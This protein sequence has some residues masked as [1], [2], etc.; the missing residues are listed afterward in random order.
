MSDQGAATSVA[1]SDASRELLRNTSE[2]SNTTNGSSLAPINSQTQLLRLETIQDSES[3][4]VLMAMKL[5]GVLG[6]AGAIVL[7]VIKETRG[8]D[9]IVLNR[10]FVIGQVVC[11]ATMFLALTIV[12]AFW[13]WRIV[14]SYRRG[15]VWSTRR[16]KAVQAVF[17]RAVVIFIIVGGHLFLNV[18]L[19]ADP[20]S[21]CTSHVIQPVVNAFVWVSWNTLLCLLAIDSHCTNLLES[22]ERSDGMVRDKPLSYHWPKLFVWIPYTISVLWISAM[23][24]EDGHTI[25]TRVVKGGACS[26]GAEL[27]CEISPFLFAGTIVTFVAIAAY[28]AMFAYYLMRAWRQLSGQLY[29]RYRMVNMAVRLQFRFNGGMVLALI[30]GIALTWY[31]GSDACVNYAVTWYGNPPVTF[32]I[33]CFQLVSFN[34]TF[35]RRHDALTTQ[36]VLPTAILQQFAWTEADVPRKIAARV[37]Y[38]DAACAA[39]PTFIAKPLFCLETAIKLFFW[40]VLAYSYT[41]TSGVSFETMPAPIKAL[42]GEMDAAMRLFNLS[43]RHLFY[44][45]QLGTKVLVA[46][47]S[48]TIVVTVRGSAEMANY[49]QDAKFLQTAHPPRRKF[50]GRTPRVH[51]GFLA[52]WRANGIRTRVLAHISALLDSADDRSA[53]RV[54]CTGHSLGGAVAQLASF[55]I[56]RELGVSPRNI[57]VYTYGCPRIGNHTLSAEF[58]EVVPDTWHVINDQDVVTRTMKMFGLYKRAG[59]R[60]II[61]RHGDLI[62]RPNHFELSMLQNVRGGST[63]HHMTVAYQNALVAIVSSQLQASSRHDDGLHGLLGLLK[64]MP[65]V[66]AALEAHASQ[67]GTSL[68]DLVRNVAHSGIDPARSTTFSASQRF[69]PSRHASLLRAAGSADAIVAV[70]AVD[71]AEPGSPASDTSVNVMPVAMLEPEEDVGDAPSMLCQDVSPAP[72]T[73]GAVG[74]AAPEAGNVSDA[75]AAA[76]RLQRWRSATNKARAAVRIS[77]SVQSAQGAQPDA[78]KPATLPAEADSV[79]GEEIAAKYCY[80]IPER[81]G[82]AGEGRG[83]YEGPAAGEHGAHKKK[84]CRWHCP[85]TCRPEELPEGAKLRGCLLEMGEAPDMKSCKG[86]WAGGGSVRMAAAAA[87]QRA[88]SGGAAEAVPPQPRAAADVGVSLAMRATSGPHAVSGDLGAAGAGVAD[89]AGGFGDAAIQDRLPVP[90]GERSGAAWGLG[91][92]VRPGVVGGAADQGDEARQIRGGAVVAEVCREPE[93]SVADVALI[94][95]DSS[96]Q[97]SSRGAQGPG[98]GGGEEAAEEAFTTAAAAPNDETDV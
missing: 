79:L 38:I 67:L 59:Q 92:A 74:A 8:R 94:A 98:G 77:R 90:P 39:C 56:A 5:S 27:E 66:R 6:V 69:T 21:F 40:S 35:P 80:P 37:G 26:W 53:V 13:T 20:G 1:S 93:Q 31:L 3:R 63:A 19:G 95:L 88:R 50:K 75:T 62:V 51:Q 82:G 2:G 47:N 68:L 4:R 17:I 61:N 46:W 7:G 9:L 83:L 70:A 24:M 32:V 44:D 28:L 54:L 42:I 22:K 97:S 25:N 15:M 96:S 55:D 64:E 30:F 23:G 52:T 72:D 12:F 41:E 78:A 57:K 81:S 10:N 85:L 43:K 34:L 87:Q 14:D 11:F 58:Q 16:R 76:R 60:A 65:Q 45:R 71:R 48:S 91:A 86:T 84:N 49:L 33:V 89:E 29:Q 18:H 73:L 36:H